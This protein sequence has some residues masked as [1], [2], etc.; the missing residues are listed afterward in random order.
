VAIKRNRWLVGTVLTLAL[1]AFLSLSLLPI[2]GSNSRRTDGN[3]NPDQPADPAAM[4]AELE[5]QA[6]GYELVLEREPENQ[7]AL[8]GLVDTR[9]Q[10]GDIEGVVDP[11]QKLVDLNPEVTDYA[12]LLAQTKQ[13]IGDLEGA[14][15]TYRDVLDQRPG[16]MNALQGLVALLVQQNRPQAA[17]GLLQETLTAA[18]QLGAGGTPSGIDTISVK[19]LLAQVYVEADQTEQALSIY[20]ETIATAPED[21]RPVLAKALVLQEAGQNDEAKTLFA[22]ATAMAPA[23]FKDQI[24]QMASPSLGGA[25][26]TEGAE[27]GTAPGAEGELEPTPADTEVPTDMENSSEVD[28]E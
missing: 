18:E 15:Q 13:Q 26:P 7:T 17:I 19:L 23:Q 10:M 4:Q 11:L 16:D 14:A 21:F 20:D 6:R 28:S 8:E 2:L 22:Q 12:V 27:E 24:E 9:I 1:A 5:A 25:A 3:A